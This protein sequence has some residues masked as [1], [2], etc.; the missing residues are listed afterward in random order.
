M[1]FCALPS[2][3]LIWRHVACENNL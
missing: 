3:A 2:S 1:S